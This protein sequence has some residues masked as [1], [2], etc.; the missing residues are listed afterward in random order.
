MNNERL[1]D[2]TLFMRSI[3]VSAKA[4]TSLDDTRKQETWS[5]SWGIAEVRVEGEALGDVTDSLLTDY[6]RTW[7]AVRP[8][9]RPRLLRVH[10][11]VRE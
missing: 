3:L 9:S 2:H 6:T 7:A 4:S 1:C 10:T 8:V 5:S 11:N